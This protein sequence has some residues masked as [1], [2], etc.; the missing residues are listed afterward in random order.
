MGFEILGLGKR[1]S[2]WR[3]Y[4]DIFWWVAGQKKFRDLGFEKRIPG[5]AATPEDVWSLTGVSSKGP[6]VVWALT[7]VSNKGPARIQKF[8]GPPLEYQTSFHKFLDPHWGLGSDIFWWVAGQKNFGVWG[9]GF[10]ILGFEKRIPGGYF[11]AQ[12][13]GVNYLRK[14]QKLQKVIIAPDS[15]QFYQVN[16]TT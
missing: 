2:G 11:E 14:N 15:Q 4:V 8:S 6:E 7:G 10:E 3:K 12:D 16:L 5:G 1:T 9:L 13:P